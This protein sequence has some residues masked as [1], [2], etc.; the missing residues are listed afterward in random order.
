M[1]IAQGKKQYTSN[2]SAVKEK[3]TGHGDREH[4]TFSGQ[5]DKNRK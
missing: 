4:R 2:L 3:F 5:P 1:S